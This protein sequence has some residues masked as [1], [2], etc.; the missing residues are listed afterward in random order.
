MASLEIM[1]T[2]ANY[3]YP[4][5]AKLFRWTEDADGTC[6][7]QRALPGHPEDG[8]GRLFFQWNAGGFHTPGQQTVSSPPL[9][10]APGYPWAVF[11]V[12][13]ACAE[14]SAFSCL[15]WWK[16]HTP[17]TWN[18]TLQYAAYA[19]ILDI[20]E[21]DHQRREQTNRYL[22]TGVMPESLV[23]CFAARVNGEQADSKW[24]Q[25]FSSSNCC[26]NF[27]DVIYTRITNMP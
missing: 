24:C 1:V 6:R 12:G 18:N 27:Q 3:S 11:I 10:P 7:G 16:L 26:A 17:G 22:A 9:Q 19:G 21:S 5:L 14:T 13:D 4:K 2:R 20:A 8:N 15:Y 23:P 25:T